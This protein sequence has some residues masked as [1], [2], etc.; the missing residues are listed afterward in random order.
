MMSSKFAKKIQLADKAEVVKLYYKH[1]SPAIINKI[2]KEIYPGMK[3]LSRQ[4][5]YKI[6]KKFELHGTVND[7]RKR[8]CGRLRSAMSDKNIESLRTVIWET[9]TKSVRMI[10][11]EKLLMLAIP[12]FIEYYLRHDLKIT[13]YK[14]SIMQH[15]K[16]TEKQSRLTFAKWIKESD[17]IVDSI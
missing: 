14:V 12:L 8:A 15:L 2:L 17:D 7:R 13:P 5:T 11:K 1:K 10:D 6:V 9:P 3:T 4:K 16:P